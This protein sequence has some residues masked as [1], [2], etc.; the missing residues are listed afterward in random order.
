MRGKDI[1]YN[2]MFFG[3]A[4]IDGINNDHRLYIES[5]KV[6]SELRQYLNSS[7]Y[8]VKIK[9]YQEI[10]NDLNEE[11]NA[12][13]KIWISSMSSYAIYDSIKNKV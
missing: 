6:N 9:E 7:Q 1:P 4:L 5:D 13:K 11:S 10:F 2:P 8:Q 3:Y 12:G